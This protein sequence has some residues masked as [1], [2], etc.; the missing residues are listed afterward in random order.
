MGGTENFNILKL[1]VRPTAH[2]LK[3]RRGNCL[4]E[5]IVLTFRALA[6]MRM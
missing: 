6:F 4:A 1:R 3:Y 5:N 2:I